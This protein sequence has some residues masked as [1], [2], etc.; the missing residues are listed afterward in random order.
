M[1]TYATPLPK[2]PWVR[3]DV[4]MAWREDT[5]LQVGDGPR[6]AVV[7]HADRALVAW[8]L[9]LQ[10][11]RT[12]E[13]ALVD[14]ERSG[15]HRGRALSLLRQVVPTGMVDDS[16]EIP[17]RLRGA[18][19][20]L[21]ARLAG[22]LAAA[23]LARGTAQAARQA[24]DRRLECVVSVHGDGPLAEAVAAA[25]MASGVVSIARESRPSSSV[26][27][28]RRRGARRSCHVLCDIA[29][30]DA[31]DAPDAMALDVP[32]LPV[33]TLGARAVVGPFVLP[34]LT[35][36]LRCLDLHR[37]DRDPAW[38]RIAVQL[39]HQRIQTPPV[40]TALAMGAAAWATLQVLAWVEAEEPAVG[41]LGWPNG[42]PATAPPAV[43]GRLTITAPGGAIDRAECPPHPLCGCRWP[44]TGR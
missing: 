19:P 17:A 22:G 39:Q 9:T 37:A 32:H 11:E 15:L 31:S 23:R 3:G 4:P 13:E 24:M 10:G 18:T 41:S 12:L 7:Q 2:R 21:R 5:T 43:G 30:P 34:G 40:D 28:A 16:D 25:L 20:D 44:N 27:R 35:G 26:R 8:L 38:P 1:P 36:C 6:T 42:W 29:H 33:A 14:A